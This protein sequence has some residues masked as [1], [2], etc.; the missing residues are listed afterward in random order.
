MTS[1]EAAILTAIQRSAFAWQKRNFGE[2]NGLLMI[3]GMVEEMGEALSGMNDI[4]EYVDGVSD[5]AIFLMQLCS[6]CKWDIGELYEQRELFELPSRPWPI[7]LGRISH[8]FVKGRVSHY[9]GTQAEHDMRCRAAISA[10]LRH[11]D[12]HLASMGQAFVSVVE[13]T[14]VIV[15]QRDWTKERPVPAEREPMHT[16]PELPASVADEI[17]SALSR[18]SQEANDTE[19]PPPFTHDEVGTLD[20]IVR[21]LGDDEPKG[22]A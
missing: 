8:H 15:S 7:L 1:A 16:M 20:P 2:P 3:A 21:T 12:E 14:W 11:W 13:A 4:A 19:R 9:R 10:L 5:C 18:A 17:E 6:V 22:A